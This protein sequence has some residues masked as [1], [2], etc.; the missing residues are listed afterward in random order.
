MSQKQFSRCTQKFTLLLLITIIVTRDS[1]AKIIFISIQLKNLNQYI[2][3]IL[4]LTSGI[5]ERIRGY[6]AYNNFSIQQRGELPL[7]V[8]SPP[9]SQSKDPLKESF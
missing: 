8:I 2:Y 6:M 4:F 3:F 9:L 7:G 5:V 1:L